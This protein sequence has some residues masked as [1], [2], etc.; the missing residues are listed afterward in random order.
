M[1]TYGPHESLKSD[2]VV[3]NF[4]LDEALGLTFVK[5]SVSSFPL[6]IGYSPEGGYLLQVKSSG[7]TIC[8]DVYYIKTFGGAM[9]VIRVHLIRD[10]FVA[11]PE[12]VKDSDIKNTTFYDMM[13]VTHVYDL[14]LK[15][16]VHTSPPYRYN[17][18][19]HPLKYDRAAI[20]GLDSHES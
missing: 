20:P 17:H 2:I 12:T 16:H 19:I 1:G 15:K 14:E 6:S 7:K 18:D 13:A 10:R 3:H 8:Q 4:K 5:K 11:Y 9:G